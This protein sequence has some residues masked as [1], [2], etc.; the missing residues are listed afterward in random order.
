[1]ERQTENKQ[2]IASNQVSGNDDASAAL[3]EL[4]LEAQKAQH[5]RSKLTITPEEILNTFEKFKDEMDKDGDGFI[6]AEDKSH[7]ELTDASKREQLI[8]GAM[9]LF[10]EGIKE[11]HDD[12]FGLESKGVTTNDIKQ[13]STD[14]NLDS[15]L[16]LLRKIDSFVSLSDEHR[17]NLLYGYDNHMR[18]KQYQWGRTAADIG[19]W[20]GLTLAGAATVL[21]DGFAFPLLPLGYH[22]GRGIGEGIGKKFA[23]MIVGS[24]SD[25]VDDSTARLLESKDKA[26]DPRYNRLSPL[27]HPL[28][29]IHPAQ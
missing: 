18:Y 6:E 1:M 8:M 4:S 19:G 11:Q 24:Y 2:D 16:F 12:E 26:L 22:G 25:Y 20:T 5:H 28:E 17:T 29:L 3:V 13:L 27:N 23:T 21:S 7:Y 9:V 15:N 10:G 14:W